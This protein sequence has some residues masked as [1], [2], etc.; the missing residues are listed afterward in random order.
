MSTLPLS[1]H[2]AS[3]ANFESSI[4]HGLVHEPHEL[5]KA[6]RVSLLLSYIR[7]I[8]L[9]APIDIFIAPKS[10]GSFIW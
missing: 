4:E 9:A 5:K 8:F 3:C 10:G 7:G 2:C 1:S 6:V